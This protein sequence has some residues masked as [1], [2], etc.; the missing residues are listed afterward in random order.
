MISIEKAI[1]LA[2]ECVEV[3]R[4]QRYAAGD[5]AYRMG[6]RPDK[7]EDDEITGTAFLFAESDHAGYVELTEV[8]RQLE[9]LPEILADPGVTVEEQ[10]I[11]F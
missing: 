8:I 11:M 1:Q 7:I 3:V 5:A 6:I 9:D 4:R 2:I 10:I